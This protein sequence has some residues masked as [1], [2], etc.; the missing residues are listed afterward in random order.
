[1]TDSDGRTPLYYA[2]KN[3]H[4]QTAALLEE[5]VRKKSRAAGT[6]GAKK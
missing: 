6:A 1:M 5:I 3:Y 4:P 2:K